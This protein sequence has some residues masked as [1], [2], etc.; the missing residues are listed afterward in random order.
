MQYEGDDRL[1]RLIARLPPRVRSAMRWLRKPSSRWV[2]IP[3]GVLL[4]LGSF[5]SI[6]PVFGLWMLPAGLLLL[7]E[8]FPPLRRLNERLLAWLERRRPDWFSSPTRH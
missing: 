2:R 3:A 1:D 5:L 4:V 8:D 7:A 6:L